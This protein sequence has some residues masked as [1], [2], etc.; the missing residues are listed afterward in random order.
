MTRS[1]HDSWDLRSGVGTTATMV[2]AA[3]AVAS[4]QPHAIINDPWAAPLVEAVGIESVTRM[5][6]LGAPPA[7]AELGNNLRL[8]PMIDSFAVRTR[9]FDE[10]F[11]TATNSGVR[12]V[13]ILAAGLDS[14]AYRLP[15]PRGTVVYEVDL[16]R[17]LSFKADVFSRLEAPPLA[18]YRQVACDLRDD[19]ATALR[20]SGFDGL[21]PTAWSAE[22]LLMYLP[23]HAQDRLFDIIT[24]L[25]APGSQLAT[26]F[27]PDGRHEVSRRMI[28]DVRWRANGI[29]ID[30][31]PLVYN[32]ARHPVRDYLAGQGWSVAE[33]TRVSL[34]EQYGLAIP[35]DD[36]PMRNVVAVTAHLD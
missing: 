25:S 21:R 30:T 36:A 34:F 16:P 5:V 17:V 4:R 18:S 28:S 7:D 6:Q 14:R 2:A 19:W 3:R 15:W 10:F 27:H 33:Q 35:E 1:D 24:A 22:G 9:F 8:Q 13:V 32:G 26:E 31:A 12:Q 11:T 29:D 20:G 23:P